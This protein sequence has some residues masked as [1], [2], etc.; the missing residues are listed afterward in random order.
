[1]NGRFKL[2]VL[3]E[4]AVYVFNRDMSALLLDRIETMEGDVC[5]ALRRDLRRALRI[6]D[7]LEQPLSE[8]P[9][10][11]DGE[12]EDEGGQVFVDAGAV[13]KNVS[14]ENAEACGDCRAPRC[15]FCD[16]PGTRAGG[17]KDGAGRTVERYYVC[18]T[19][20]CIAAKIKTPQPMGLFSGGG[21]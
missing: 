5:A 13:I 9:V 12:E 19:A 4:G 2:E 15:R 1:M 6:A 20:G 3:L 11:D 8:A 14:K 18:E 21:K 17:R 10:P 16:K 7:G